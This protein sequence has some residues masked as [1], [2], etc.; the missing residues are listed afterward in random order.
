MVC[1]QTLIG[2]AKNL[3]SVLCPFCDIDRAKVAEDAITNANLKI[4]GNI[5]SPRNLAEKLEVMWVLEVFD[6]HRF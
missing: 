1:R 6:V 3:R 2:E 4:C 5:N